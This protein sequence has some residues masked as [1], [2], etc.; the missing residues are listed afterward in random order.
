MPAGRAAVWSSGSDLQVSPRAREPIRSG[1]PAVSG[2]RRRSAAV[3]FHGGAP[4]IWQERRNLRNL[5]GAIF[6]GGIAG[7]VFL[8]FGLVRAAAADGYNRHFESGEQSVDKQ[9]G[10]DDK[11]LNYRCNVTRNGNR[12]QKW[13]WCPHQLNQP[14]FRHTGIAQRQSLAPKLNVRA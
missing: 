1:R 2:S 7:P 6:F 5:A 3:A 12:G 11:E 8:M 10:N 4:E 9:A 14:E 13:R